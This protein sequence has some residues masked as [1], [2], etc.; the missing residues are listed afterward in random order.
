M[1]PKIKEIELP[2]LGAATAARKSPTA[3]GKC[4]S[5]LRPTPPAELQGAAGSGHL[6]ADSTAGRLGGTPA[7]LHAT[8]ECLGPDPQRGG[9]LA[10]APQ[11]PLAC[12]PLLPKAAV[13]RVGVVAHHE[14]LAGC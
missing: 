6:G 13:A 3:S 10:R 5:H 9:H 1:V 2:G 4:P 7:D 12:G 8:T 14:V 11:Q